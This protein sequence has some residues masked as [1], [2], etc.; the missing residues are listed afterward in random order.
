MLV[1]GGLVGITFI[2]IF[3]INNS[4]YNDKQNLINVIDKNLVDCSSNRKC[5]NLR[6][7]QLIF[8]S[9]TYFGD[10]NAIDTYFKI[11][12]KDLIVK[13]SVEECEVTQE[14]V[15]DEWKSKYFIIINLKIL[16]YIAKINWYYSSHFISN[17]SPAFIKFKNSNITVPTTAITNFGSGFERIPLK[18][19]DVKDAIPKIDERNRSRWKN[20]WLNQLYYSYTAFGSTDGDLRI[21]YYKLKTPDKISIIGAKNG[22]E[23]VP[24]TNLEGYKDVKIFKS[25]GDDI[26]V[27]DLLELLRGEGYGVYIALKIV[28]IIII[29][30]SVLIIGAAFKS[31]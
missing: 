17:I 31:D 8:Y 6:N 11:E 25:Y 19:D 9:G 5:D 28:S 14:I 26:K 23:I 16:I 12:F 15:D 1:C 20:I 18:D 22:N 4:I 21:S 13:R 27:D 3:F 29:I 7:D 2:I 10:S 24:H 30:I